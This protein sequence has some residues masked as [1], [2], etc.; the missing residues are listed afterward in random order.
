MKRNLKKKKKKFTENCPLMEAVS[1][2]SVKVRLGDED[3]EIVP[4]GGAYRAEN[5]CLVRYFT[6]PDFYIS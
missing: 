2:F 1:D 3:N 6:N 5:F 4:S